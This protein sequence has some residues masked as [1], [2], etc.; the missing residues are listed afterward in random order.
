[1][2]VRYLFITGGVVSSLGKGILTAS[3]GLLLQRRGLRVVPLKFDPYLNVDPGTMNPYQHGEVFVT[4]DGAET[5]LDL[6]HYERFLHQDMHREN[7]VTA[8]QVYYE[9]ILKERAGRFLGKTVQVVPHLTREI[10]ERIRR[11]AREDVDVVIVEV[12]GTVGDIESLPFLE[13]IRQFHLDIGKEN[14]LFVHL[15]LVPYLGTAEE[16][17]TK[18][19]QH[20]VMK[21][22]EIGIQ[23]DFILC[24]SEKHLPKAVREKIALFTNVPVD[25][26]F[27]IPYVGTIYEVPL[28]LHKQGVDQVIARLWHLP[29][30]PQLDDWRDLVKRIKHPR[31]EVTVA[32]AGKYVHMKDTYKSVYE[33]ITHAAAHLRLRVHLRRVDTQRVERE[34]AEAYL[35]DVDAV[36]VPGGFGKRG[37][38]GMIQVARYAR[39]HGLPYLGLCLGMQVAVIEFARHVVGWVDAHST[40]FDPQTS[41]PVIVLLPEQKGVRQIGGTLRLGAYTARVTPGSLLH[42]I[43]GSLQITE[44]HRHRYEFNPEVRKPLEEAG[45]RVAAESTEGHLV[46]AIEIPGHPFFVAV[47]YHPEFRSRPLNPHPLFV[48]FLRAALEH[49][50][51]RYPLLADA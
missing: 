37:V 21:L 25:H 3:L 13:A 14:A 6:G 34:G 36:L 28:V 9:L 41:H 8:G 12:G 2:P 49:H 43:Y 18:P 38:E 11:L 35:R 16:L 20:S 31:Q 29:G 4:E 44:R 10:Q 17:K 46:E 33:A 5:D 47:Q 24:R 32:L 23:P 48:G 40:E 7:N 45:L 27:E 26:V 50:E 15:T 1:M 19:T 22:R 30:T 51:R 39:E 42:Q